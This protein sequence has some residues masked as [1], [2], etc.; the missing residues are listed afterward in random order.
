MSPS[1][2]HKPSSASPH[3]YPP[4]HPLTHPNH[5]QPHLDSLVRPRASPS[6][7]HHPSIADRSTTSPLV[8][9]KYS[10]ALVAAGAAFV[11]AQ[12]VASL[13]EC[14]VS[15][16]L[17]GRPAI[18]ISRARCNAQCACDAIDIDATGTRLTSLLAHLHQQHARHCDFPVRLRPERR[19]L[20]LQGAQLR[21]RCP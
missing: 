5:I 15:V 20:L 21:L 7:E 6:H 17:L 2:K 9:M 19:P 11:A 8:K 3:C 13:P 14:G 18:G 4:L 1:A 16:F 10:L 12:D